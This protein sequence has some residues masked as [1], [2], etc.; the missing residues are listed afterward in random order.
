[1]N[2]MNI[3][4][5]DTKIKGRDAIT[6][7]QVKY[8]KRLIIEKD[9]DNPFSSNEELWFHL[10]KHEARIAIKYILFDYK[11]IWEMPE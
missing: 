7:K 9:I 4:L 6:L 11:I 5:S 1:M 10:S 3:I 2:E 8:L